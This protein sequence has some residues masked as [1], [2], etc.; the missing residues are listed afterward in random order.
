MQGPLTIKIDNIRDYIK[1][2]I[3]N[4]YKQKEFTDKVKRQGNKSIPNKGSQLDKIIYTIVAMQLE[5]SS[6]YSK[7]L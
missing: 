5:N 4:V 2:K 1:N 6:N 7:I 3:T